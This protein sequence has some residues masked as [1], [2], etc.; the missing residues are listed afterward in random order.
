MINVS[1]NNIQFK[2]K[3]NKRKSSSIIKEVWFEDAFRSANMISFTDDIATLYTNLQRW[4][5]AQSFDINK[6]EKVIWT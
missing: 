4:C 6:V 3:T 2:K 5:I 1:Y